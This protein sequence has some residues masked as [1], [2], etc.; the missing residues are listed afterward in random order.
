[1]LSF[2]V[3]LMLYEGIGHLERE[4]SSRAEKELWTSK[5]LFLKISELDPS[6]G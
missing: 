4:G 2:Q 5:E 1:M 3:L 6:L